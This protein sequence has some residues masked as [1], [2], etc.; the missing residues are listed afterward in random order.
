[1]LSNARFG[2]HLAFIAWLGLVLLYMFNRTEHE[3]ISRPLETNKGLLIRSFVLPPPPGLSKQVGE[4][5]V[6]VEVIREENLQTASPR[7]KKNGR[8]WLTK[9]EQGE[10]PDI[11]FFWPEDV[12]ERHWILQRLY[13]CGIRLGKWREDR[14]IAVEPGRSAVSGFLRII[15]GT[16]TPSEQSRLHALLGQGQAVRLFPRGLD[17]RLL[18]NLSALTSGAFF[19]A[20]TAH[21][22]YYRQGNALIIGD[23]QIDGQYTRKDIVLFPADGSCG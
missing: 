2:W 11:N 12:Q 18:S 17:I 9:L 8:I 5:E 15:S 3:L 21:A 19:Q 23:I 16:V 7:D 4:S 13:D 14:L 20:K 10:G 22:G 1:M 6:G